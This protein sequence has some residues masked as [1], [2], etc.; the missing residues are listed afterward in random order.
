[1]SG[2]PRAGAPHSPNNLALPR[3]ASLTQVSHKSHASLTQVSRKSHA[4]L[5]QVS[6]KSHASLTQVSRKSHASLTR[7][8]FRC[9]TPFFLDITPTFFFLQSTRPRDNAR[10]AERPDWRR[11]AMAALPAANSAQFHRNWGPDCCVAACM[12]TSTSRIGGSLTR[13]RECWRHASIRLG[14]HG[15]IH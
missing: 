11:A 8:F 13:S 6:R 9:H 1:M 7:H 2:A 10:V 15:T 3:Q 14:E 12:V 4:S 5:T